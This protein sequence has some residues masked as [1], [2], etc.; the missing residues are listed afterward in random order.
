MTH[1]SKA[2][3]ARWADVPRGPNAEII[4]TDSNGVALDMQAGKDLRTLERLRQVVESDFKAALSLESL[5]GQQLVAAQKNAD[6][7][8]RARLQAEEAIA[9]IDRAMD[10]VRNAR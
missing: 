6:E 5:C 4:H 7:A 3:F 10:L 2:Q 1:N 9:C 8:K